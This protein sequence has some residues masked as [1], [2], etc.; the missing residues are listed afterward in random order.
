MI[1]ANVAAADAD[2]RAQV[3]LFMSA[4]A[5]AATAAFRSSVRP[6]Y[7]ASVRKT[8]E[9][10]GSCVLLEVDGQK[11]VVTAAHIIDH[12]ACTTLYIGGSD[13]LV[14]MVAEFSATTAPRD[15]RDLDH[16][17]FAFAQLGAESVAKLGEVH[18]LTA[19]QI[20]PSVSTPRRLFTALGY[21][22]S[23]NERVN[24]AAK[25]VPC[26][27]YP[28]SSLHS[29]DRKLATRLKITGQHHLF[30]DHRDHAADKDGQKAFAISPRGMSGGAVIEATE[31]S[32]P[33]FRGSRST[34]PRLAGIVVERHGN[35]LLA[36][37]IDVIVAVIR[38]AEVAAST[39]DCDGLAKI[40][41]TGDD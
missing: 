3:R 40:I 41:R 10:I 15:D 39:A 29:F 31:T 34:V 9:Q 19:S 35:T 2:F 8:A 28:Y 27:L 36:T 25:T 38:S 17:D 14:P 26:K 37:R 22:N 6:I 30:I 11:F 21:P 13:A 24:V 23:Q 33:F 16:Y 7:G 20:L 18:F 1:P 12:N 5:D 4:A 32:L